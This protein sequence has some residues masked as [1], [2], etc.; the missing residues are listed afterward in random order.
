LG[1]F[2]FFLL[3]L[4]RYHRQR[5]TRF[6]GEEGVTLP[7]WAWLAL[8]Y[9]LFI[10]SSLNLTTVQEDSPDMCVA[11]LMYLAS[12]ILLRVRMGFA[13][14]LTFALLGAVLGIGYLA[15]AFMLQLA[16]VVLGIGLLSMGNIRRAA[17]RVLIA[18]SVSLASSSSERGLLQPT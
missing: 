3:E 11:A 16:V 17:P 14:W 2:Y 4:I 1:C 5:A 7:E 6:S 15:K 12:G 13:S 9:T 18:G 8:G 10:W